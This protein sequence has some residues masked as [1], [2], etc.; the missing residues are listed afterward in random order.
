VFNRATKASGYA[1]GSATGDT[2]SLVMLDARLTELEKSKNTDRVIFKMGTFEKPHDLFLT[3]LKFDAIK[4]ESRINPQQKD[5]A[6]GKTELVNFRSRFGKDLQGTLIYPADYRPGQRYPMVT[7]IYERLSD[8]LHN[9]VNP[10]EWSSYNTQ[11]LSQNGYFVFMPDLTYVPRN[12]GKS[13]VDCLEPAIDAVLAKKVGVDESRIGL[14]GHSWGGYQTAFVTTVSKKFKVGVAG[15]PLTELTSMYNSF[16]WNSGTSD[17]EL[18]ETGQGRMQVPFWEDPKA[19]ME[20]SP[21]WQSQKRTAPIL[22]AAGDADGAVDWHQPLYLYQTLRR[23]GKDAVLLV[24]AGEN[25]NFTRR[26]NQL[27]YS[28]R[29]RHFLDVHLKGAKPEAW[30]TSGVPFL[31]KDD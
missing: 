16:Y 5:F 9:Y 1:S 29:L 3:N 12:P 8:G 27:D 28:R 22:M 23:M 10:V 19:Y 30:V 7:Y 26:P 24:Y 2:K 31:K 6:W 11:A 18:M 20:N 17:Q 13:A 4:P 15:A 21:V 14:M 25:H